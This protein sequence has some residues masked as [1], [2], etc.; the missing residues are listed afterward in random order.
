MSRKINKNKILNSS[1]FLSIIIVIYYVY[2]FNFGIIKLET[3]NIK[4]FSSNQ[5]KSQII[6]NDKYEI[7]STS[8]LKKIFCSKPSN[9]NFC[10]SSNKNFNSYFDCYETIITLNNSIYFLFVFFLGS[11]INCKQL[12]KLGVL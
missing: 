10:N 7:K 6:K 9:L 5:F 4:K 12:I 11:F 8:V 2:W 1:K 3:K